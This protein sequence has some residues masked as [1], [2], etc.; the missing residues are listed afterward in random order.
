[1]AA[2]AAG[3]GWRKEPLPPKVPAPAKSD[4]CV[5]CDK[6]A[7]HVDVAGSVRH[8]CC[9][10][11]TCCSEGH[12]GWTREPLT[13]SEPAPLPALPPLEEI[14]EASLSARSGGCP[15]PEVVQCREN[16]DGSIDGKCVKCGDDT[17]V[18]REPL[19]DD[20]G[21][22]DVPALI[23]AECDAVRDL[24]LAKNAKYGNSALE[25]ARIFSKANP[26]EQILVRIDDKLSRIRTTGVGA[27][28]DED[29][30][31]DLIGYL[32]LLR[33]AQRKAK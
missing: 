29:T 1:M 22:L 10:S 32:I 14:A 25:P 24:L 7:N 17:F 16:A 5:M 20:L 4:D 18:I 26:V 13:P 6:P 15:H 19:V 21:N 11:R 3:S 33:V 2:T 8:R 12:T 30:V 31:K 23:A 28:P 9:G 27:Q